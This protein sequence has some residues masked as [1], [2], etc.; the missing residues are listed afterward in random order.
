MSIIVD[1]GAYTN[2]AG[3]RWTREAAAR[4]LAAGYRPSQKQMA[5]PLNVQGVGNGHQTAKWA[6]EMPIAVPSADGTAQLH[7][8]ES[9]T[10]GGTG[11]SLPALLG[12]KSISANKGVLETIPGAAMLTFPGPAGYTVTWRPG[13]RHFPLTAAPSGHLVIPCDHF[14]MIPPE[15]GGLRTQGLSLLAAVHE[16]SSSDSGSRSS[17][18]AAAPPTTFSPH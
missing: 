4:A 13:T 17:P 10:V 5:Q 15:S 1:P 12:L 9:P 7:T 2:L 11:E 14:E 8:F 6:T 3:A 16:S 18:Q